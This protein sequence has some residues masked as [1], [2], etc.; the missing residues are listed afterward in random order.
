MKSAGFHFREYK[1]SFLL[2]K[3]KNFFNIRARKLHSQKCSEFFF[4]VDFFYFFKCPRQPLN[5]LLKCLNKLCNNLVSSL[6]FNPSAVLFVETQSAYYIICRTT[7]NLFTN[8]WPS[9]QWK[10]V[11]THMLKI[12]NTS[13]CAN[14]ESILFTIF[15]TWC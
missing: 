9:G 1:K 5:I 8:F 3:Y 2:K 12:G 6:P 11:V 7:W 14:L 15:L 13:V 10:Y 4:G